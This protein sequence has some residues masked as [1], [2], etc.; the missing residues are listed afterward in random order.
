[1]LL[2]GP[3]LKRTPFL[4]EVRGH[5]RDAGELPG[6]RGRRTVRSQREEDVAHL[7]VERPLGQKE[8][9]RRWRRRRR[10]LL[11]TS[12]LPATATACFLM[13]SVKNSNNERARARETKVWEGSPDDQY[14]MAKAS[15]VT[16]QSTARVRRCV[17]CR[18]RLA[19]AIPHLSRPMFFGCERF[20]ALKPPMDV[21]PLPRRSQHLKPKRRNTTKITERA[22]RVWRWNR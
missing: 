20:E 14:L 1:M 9:R 2:Y 11:P 17:Q 6:P 18:G 21:Q 15:N 16:S 19:S 8:G 12:L 7:G 22:K 4:A 13:W 10:R 5:E 3:D